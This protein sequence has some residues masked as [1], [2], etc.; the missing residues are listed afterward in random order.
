MATP[1]AGSRTPAGAPERG[2]RRALFALVVL[3]AL[4]TAACGTT[5]PSSSRAIARH[6]VEG[7]TLTY[8]YTPGNVFNW[9]LPFPV[10]SNYTQWNDDIVYGMWRPLYWAGLGN[11]PVIDF[12]RS[13]AYPPV[14]SDHDTV[15]T[16]RLK[17]ERWSDGDPVTTSDV[18]FFFQLLDAGKK[19]VAY[20]IPGDIPDN[21][22]S[23]DYV[24]PSEF[25]MHLTGSFSQQWYLDNEL[26]D[27]VPLPV[28][29]W[30]RTSMSGHATDAASTAAG[31]TK[32]FDFLSGQA[33]K[34]STYATNP[35]WQVVDGPWRLYGYNPTTSE[36]VVVRNASYTGADKP[37]LDKV[38][39]ET[40]TSDTAELVELRSGQLDYGFLPISDYEGLKGYFSTHGFTVAPWAPDYVQWAELGYTGPYGKLFDQL[41][42]RQ[43]LQHLVNERLYLTKVLHGLGQYTYGPVPNIAGSPDV[44][45]EEKTDPD[46]YSLDAARSLLASHGWTGGPSGTLR[47]SHPGTG[48]GHCGAGIAVGTSLQIP[49]IIQSGYPTVVAQA[50]AFQSA[51][52]AVGISITIEPDPVGEI[53][54]V[55]AVC[56]P[57]PCKW[58]II[59]FDSWIWDYGQQQAYP[60]G[61]QTFSKGNYWGGGYFSP[62]AQHLIDLT[63]TRSGLSYLFSYE[64]YISRQVA[65]L[66]FPTADNEI[67]VVKDSVGGWR[68]QGVFNDPE[69]SRWFFRS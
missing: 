37:H 62:T 9:I 20:Y 47:C 53:Y 10:E 50:E 18:R 67:S 27:I 40:P 16:I 52:R 12:K 43:A 60:T 41:Y 64:N 69:V 1:S 26:V 55:G 44:S 66:W 25:V 7:G 39:Y 65:A 14:W 13:F 15:V 68:P 63:H 57:G 51:A 6:V 33:K 38:V 8:A 21:V 11:K 4:V 42:L 22:A 32:V 58:G 46:P 49:M 54:S 56:P 34:L 48:P 5:T 28:Q 3:V 24:S 17:H 45:P 31:A 35:L 36:T 2:V 61:G 59:L 30:D 23:I 19:Q 29:S